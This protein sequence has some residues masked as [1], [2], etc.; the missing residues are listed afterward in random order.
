MCLRLCRCSIEQ[1][2]HTITQTVESM[3]SVSRGRSK[4]PTQRTQPA[5]VRQA[6]PKKQRKSSAS[7][8]S[9]PNAASS[10]PEKKKSASRSSSAA[11]SLPT[12][13]RRSAS[14]PGRVS[15]KGATAARDV[16]DGVDL[17][18]GVPVDRS[19]TFAY[20]ATS[21]VPRKPLLRRILGSWAVEVAHILFE[22]W[23]QALTFLLYGVVLWPLVW[24][25]WRVTMFALQA[26]G[27]DDAVNEG[28]RLMSSSS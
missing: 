11:G 26:S 7:R 20:A 17:V 12:P 1:P 13:A 10:T 8:K 5:A 4:T 16:V 24:G 3:P 28:V 25:L 22:P 21:H 2:R 19:K 27:F 15:T 14:K 18:F 6:S 9:E 23:E